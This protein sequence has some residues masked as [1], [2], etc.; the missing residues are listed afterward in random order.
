MPETCS[1]QHLRYLGRNRYQCQACWAYLH[2]VVDDDGVFHIE[3]E[4]KNGNG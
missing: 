3:E 2:R 1:H 4:K